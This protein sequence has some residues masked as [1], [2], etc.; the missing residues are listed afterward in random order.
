M[1]VA[2]G[3]VGGTEAAP[4]RRQC[5]AGTKAAPEQSVYQPCRRCAPRRF[6]APSLPEFRY[7]CV[8]AASLARRSATTAGSDGGV[9]ASRPPGRRTPPAPADHRLVVAGHLDVRPAG[10]GARGTGLLSSTTIGRTSRRNQTSALRSPTGDSSRVRLPPKSS[11]RSDTQVRHPRQV[12]HAVARPQLPGGGSPP[13]CDRES[14]PRHPIR[15]VRRCTEAPV[16][17]GHLSTAKP[18]KPRNGFRH[19]AH[20]SPDTR[21]FQQTRHL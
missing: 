11:R 7:E 21:L 1:E 14:G 20:G 2:G 9:G 13:R 8:Q 6:S 16:S 12:R 19:S 15:R 4:K 18:L 17:S 5:N 10:F 3:A